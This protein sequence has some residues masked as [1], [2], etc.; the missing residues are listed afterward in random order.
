MPEPT[1]ESEDEI[2]AAKE[3]LE[4]HNKYLQNHRVDQLDILKKISSAEEVW[5]DLLLVMRPQNWILLS[6]RGSR[7]S[8]VSIIGFGIKISIVQGR[9]RV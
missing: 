7:A 9:Q 2:A 8:R 1:A 3:D 6:E 4:K 5:I